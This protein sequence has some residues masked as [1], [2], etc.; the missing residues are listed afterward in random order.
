M[1]EVR[2][3]VLIHAVV[4]PL[5]SCLQKIVY[6]GTR[7]YSVVTYGTGARCGGV[8]RVLRC[9]VTRK[10]NV[11]CITF[12]LFRSRFGLVSLVGSTMCYVIVLP[13]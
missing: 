12:A 5:Q 3:H 2:E 11:K 6:Y 1:C 7:G 13:A 4:D 10:L 9:Y 8:V